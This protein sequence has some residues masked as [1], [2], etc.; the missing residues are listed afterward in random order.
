MFALRF[1]FYMVLAGAIISLPVSEAARR[2]PLSYLLGYVV[3]S[4]VEIAGAALL[5]HAS[6]RLM[7]G[8]ATFTSSMAAWCLYLTFWPV[9]AVSL[10]PVNVFFA[11]VFEGQAVTRLE[12]LAAQLSPENMLVLF[13]CFGVSTVAMVLFTRGILTTFRALHSLTFARTVAAGVFAFAGCLVFLLVIA[14]PFARS[15]YW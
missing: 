10:A 4:V 8:G 9:L 13:V 2:R 6:F 7:G 11:R 5:V 14:F 1:G 3:S 15:V 12:E